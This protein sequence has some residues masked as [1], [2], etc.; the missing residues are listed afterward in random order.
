MNRF[1]ATAFSATPPRCVGG[2]FLSRLVPARDCHKWS[3][4][5]FD[6]T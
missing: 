2:Q 5:G 4:P 1:E 3:S 6:D